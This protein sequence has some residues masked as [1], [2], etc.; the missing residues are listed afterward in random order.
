MVEMKRAL[1][2]R[3][4]MTLIELMIVVAIIGILAAIATY[5]YVKYIK[6]AKVSKLKQYAM[7]V[8]KGQEQYKS[9]N[10]TFLNMANHNFPGS[11]CDP[12]S[13]AD[14]ARWTR[15]LGFSETIQDNVTVATEAGKA[16]AS[17]STLCTNMPKPDKNAA[18][19]VVRVEQD[20]N[21]A[22]A[23]KTTVYMT[24]TMQ[25]PVV[26]NEGD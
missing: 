26:T 1:K 9:R 10:S 21:T 12:K 16:G 20:M 19:Y 8:A 3:R 13:N 24:N 2:R 7:D 17:C 23:A 14:C 25:Q 4:G 18:W 5:S 15:L 22:S 11:N 6:H